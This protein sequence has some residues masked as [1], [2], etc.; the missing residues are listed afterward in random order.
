MLMIT[1]DSLYGSVGAVLSALIV[2][3]CFAGFSL[4][5][6]VFSGIPR[7]DFFW[8]YT[9]LSNLLVAFYFSCAAPFFY[10]RRALYRFIPLAEFSV[11]MSIMLTHA[12]FHLVIF[13]GV[14][15]QLRRISSS[16]QNRMIAVNNLLVHY[17]VPW[18]VLLYYLLCSPRKNT[19]PLAA[20]PLWILFPLGYAAVVF[21]H[22]GAGK[23]IPGTGLPY[24]YPFLDVSLLGKKRVLFTCAVLCAV[25]ALGSVS[26]LCIIRALYAL[27]G[28]GRALFLVG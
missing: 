24:P 22:A 23:V 8:Y 13:P 2:V 10:A 25:C 27:L 26:V 15:P 28:G 12:V 16:I 21:L 19:L 11:T 14:K 3:A 18:L 20:A 7:K 4:H 17:A 9:N 6:D 1:P 5:S